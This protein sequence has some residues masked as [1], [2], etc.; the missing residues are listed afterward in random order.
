PGA[1]PHAAGWRHVAR[2]LPAPPGRAGP[3]RWSCWPAASDLDSVRGARRAG[4][5]SGLAGAV[6]RSVAGLAGGG[7]HRVAAKLVAQ[8]CE[9]A[10]GEGI[11]LATAAETLQQREGDDRRRNVVVAGVQHRPASFTRVGDPALDLLAIP[12]LPPEGRRR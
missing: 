5:R 6:T 9:D 10:I 1:A 11:R 7:H 12:P 8:R 4:R 3:G 2:H